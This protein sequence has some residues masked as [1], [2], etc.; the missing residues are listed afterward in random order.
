[1]ADLGLLSWMGRIQGI[2]TAG[3]SYIAPQYCTT[4]LHVRIILCAAVHT[5]DIRQ[6][7][8][9]GSKG[10]QWSS[11]RDDPN[12]G[13]G[14]VLIIFV[15][16]WPIFLLISLYLDQVIWGGVRWV[17]GW[18]GIGNWLVMILKLHAPYC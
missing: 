5:G 1:M 17:G 13:M 6:A 10:L 12:C 7:A 4:T 18:V 2:C 3:P 15:I 14:A 8:R 9:L 11:L 16:E